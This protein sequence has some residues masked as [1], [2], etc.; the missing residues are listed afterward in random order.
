MNAWLNRG[1][2][3]LAGMGSWMFGGGEGGGE[4]WVP[5]HVDLDGGWALG[6]LGQRRRLGLCLV[7]LSPP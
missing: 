2:Q 5:T 3:T 6:S 4:R 7:H 1:M